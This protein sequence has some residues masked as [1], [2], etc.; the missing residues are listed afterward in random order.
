MSARDKHPAAPA[1]ARDGAEATDSSAPTLPPESV[2]LRAPRSPDLAGTSRRHT[3]RQPVLRSGAGLARLDLLA[4]ELPLEEGVETLVRSV[5]EATRDAAPSLFVGAVVA[6]EG[7]EGQPLVVRVAPRGG[8]A[9]DPPPP[10]DGRAARL[11]PDR[12]RE[13]VVRLACEVCGHSCY[14]HW[15][16]DRARYAACKKCSCAGWDD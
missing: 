12:S 6:G 3:G 13:H 15:H 8:F 2:D 14:A 16:D 10:D 5:C 9:T 11:F 1:E 7:P 4:V